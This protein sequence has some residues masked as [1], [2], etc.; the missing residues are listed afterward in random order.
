MLKLAG[1][2]A[3][4]IQGIWLAVSG[5]D[6][7][8]PGSTG[9]IITAGYGY[10]QLLST[11]T[12]RALWLFFLGVIVV[13]GGIMLKQKQKK[14]DA[15]DDYYKKKNEEQIRIVEANT[16]CMKELK[17]VIERVERKLDH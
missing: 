5:A 7:A 13:G 3:V 15:W 14:L 16:Q 1:P 2:V 12:D 17:T 10:A 11:L 4:M 8:N 6:T 9:D